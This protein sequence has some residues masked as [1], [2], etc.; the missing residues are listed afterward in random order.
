LLDAAAPG[1]RR[2]S[3]AAFF[4]AADFARDAAG[5]ADFRADS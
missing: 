3:A 4:A 1:G 2:A 5:R